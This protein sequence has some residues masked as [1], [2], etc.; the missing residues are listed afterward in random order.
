MVGYVLNTVNI[1]T[2]LSAHEPTKDIIM[3][4]KEL[5]IRASRRTYFH[6]PHIKYVTVTIDI[7]VIP[8][9]MVHRFRGIEPEQ[10]R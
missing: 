6:Q 10:L 9:A 7:L 1:Q 4:I 8:A 2:I 3:G 5:P